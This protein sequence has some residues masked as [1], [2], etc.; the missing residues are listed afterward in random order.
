[1][2]TRQR[3]LAGIVGLAVAF[4]FA[5]N[6]DAQYGRTKSKPDKSQRAVSGQVI[7]VDTEITFVYHRPSVKGREVWGTNLAAYNKPWRTGANETTTIEVSDDVMVNGEKLAAGKY[8]LH[9]IPRAN[10]KWTI[11][12]N[13]DWETW[14]SFSYK[15]E[16]D[17]LR[18]D[19]DA[20]D[21][22]HTEQLTFSFSNVTDGSAV[23]SLRWEKKSVS[24]LFEVAE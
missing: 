9:V 18:I 15:E 7:G 12:I 14:G 24:I 11:I 6:A 19:V 1:M 10:G 20:E 5:I 23:A 21:T 16:N 4:T 3:V 2:K 22:P 13:K 8:G 17:A